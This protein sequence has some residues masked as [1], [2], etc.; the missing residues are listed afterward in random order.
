MGRVPSFVIHYSL[1]TITFAAALFEAPA[2]ALTAE[3]LRS[4]GGLPPHIVA[5]FEEPLAFQQAPGGAYYV[6]DRRGHSVYAVHS[7]KKSAVK[8]VEIGPELGRILQPRGFDTSRTGSFVVADAPRSIDRIQIF[9]AGGIRTGG[10]FLPAR[11]HQAAIE[12]GARVVSG[13]GAIQYAGSNL[14]IS[15]P[16]SGSLFTQY[17]PGGYPQRSYGRLRATGQEQDRDVH[18]ALN[19]GLP[20][21]DPTGG[22]YYVFVG[23]RPMFHKYDA[24][25]RLLFERHIEGPELDPYL[26]NL[27]T[28]WPRRRV[29]D[30]EL[31][32]V[33]PAVRSAT[34][35]AGGR[36][37]ISLVE[38][39]TYVYDAQGDKIRTVQFQ[40]AGIVAPSS[41]FF[42]DDGRLLITPGCFEFRP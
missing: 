15:H 33:H 7:D 1:L 18:L 36:L 34:V 40:A 9:G 29:E 37:W 32:L 20:L 23:G 19:V 4:T 6:F 21:P 31:P 41:L 16:E 35:D 42:T 2:V 13:I 5:L 11:D 8:L 3:T 25:G 14:V 38:P 30:R 27:P 26:A 12:F 22:F 39:Y 10:F 28:R 17:S 24:N